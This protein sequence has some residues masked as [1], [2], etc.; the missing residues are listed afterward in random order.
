MAT[1]KRNVYS[2]RTVIRLAGAGAAT[3]AFGLSATNWLQKLAKNPGPGISAPGSVA[4]TLTLA[5]G[6]L[7][8]IETVEG[9]RVVRARDARLVWRGGSVPL[10]A[11]EAGDKLWISGAVL[12][13]GTVAAELIEANIGQI[14]GLIEKV[15]SDHWVVTSGKGASS[16]V[17]F[18]P[19]RPPEVMRGGL[20]V[21]GLQSAGIS[22]GASVQVIGLTLQDGS[23]RATKVFLAATHHP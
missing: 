12:P 6:D 21:D 9:L 1:M 10:S 11:L 19:D 16:K 17:V 4:G 20:L 5:A 13:D 8:Y 2:R 14:R 23:L 3:G 7:L 22:V 15:A 18:A